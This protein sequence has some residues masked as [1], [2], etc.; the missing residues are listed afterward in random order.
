MARIEVLEN[1]RAPQSLCPHCKGMLYLDLTL[2][3]HDVSKIVESKCPKCGGK[4]FTALLIL[5]HPVLHGLAQTIAN[6]V[7][8]IDEDKR[9]LLGG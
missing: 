2:F 3:E 4:I 1:K 6:I 7:G 5:T 8:Q 9:K